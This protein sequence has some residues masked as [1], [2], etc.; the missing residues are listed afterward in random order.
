MTKYILL[1][2]LVFVINVLAS[3][4]SHAAT[5]YDPSVPPFYMMSYEE[6]GDL[7]QD[8]KDFYVEK[9]Q[10]ALAQVPALQNTTKKDIQE[11]AEWSSSWDR[12]GKKLYEFCGEKDS[13]KV[14]DNISD[15]RMQTFDIYARPNPAVREAASVAN[16]TK[17]TPKVQGVAQ[18][19]SL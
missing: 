13:Q 3:E 6:F 14:C 11:A 19:P 15:I 17:S 10:V 18:P 8:Q 4:Y 5:G 9:F 7:Q 2:V 16:K 1:T 12:M